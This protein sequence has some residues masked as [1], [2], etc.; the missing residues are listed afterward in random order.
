MQDRFENRHAALRP[1][2]ACNLWTQALHA[3]RIQALTTRPETHNA[4][5]FA[6]IGIAFGV[7]EKYTR[8][9]GLLQGRAF[10]AVKRRGHNHHG[11]PLPGGKRLDG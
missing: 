1:V 7:A 10:L 3:N 8:R 11:Q 2:E 6:P 4:C 5:R 9:A